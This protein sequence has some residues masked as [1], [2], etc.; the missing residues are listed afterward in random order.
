MRMAKVIPFKC[1]LFGGAFLKCALWNADEIRFHRLHLYMFKWL[2]ILFAVVVG[3]LF[4]LVDKN[5]NENEYEK[6][7]TELWTTMANSSGTVKRHLAY[8]TPTHVLH[9]RMWLLFFVSFV[10]IPFPQRITLYLYMRE[11]RDSVCAVHVVRYTAQRH[12][13]KVQKKHNSLHFHFTIFLFARRNCF[14][15]ILHITR[16]TIAYAHTHINRRFMKRE[17]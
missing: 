17:P 12:N 2:G 8:I 13:N 1:V 9:R 6:K 7:N 4:T 11:M 14:R 5:E 3:W 15:I 10:V 16:R